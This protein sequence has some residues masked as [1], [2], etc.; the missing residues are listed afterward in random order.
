MEDTDLET[1]G[2]HLNKISDRVDGE[3]VEWITERWWYIN[4][5]MV[6]AENGKNEYAVQVSNVKF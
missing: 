2:K 3:S 5:I 6:I 1:F 4:V